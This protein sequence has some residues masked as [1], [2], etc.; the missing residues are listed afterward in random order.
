MKSTHTKDSFGFTLI[1]LLVVIAI[2]AI[3]ASLLLPALAS[4]KNKA[5]RVK[6]ISNEKQLG[7]ALIVYSDTSADFYPAYA[8]YAA[9]GGQKGAVDIAG[10]LSNETSRV[11]NKFVQGVEVFHCPS[12]HG[13]ALSSTLIASCWTSYGNS[14]LM[15][16]HEDRYSVQYCGGDSQPYNPGMPLL[17]PIKSTTIAAKPSTKII[18]SDW[19]WFADRNINSPQSAWHNNKGNPTF[20]T[21]FGDGHVEYY[22]FPPNRTTYDRMTPN[23]TNIWW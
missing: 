14:Y 21:L 2:I 4:A 8:E 5:L 23:Q 12:D 20:P 9:W 11:V 19:P 18:L 22:K 3:L 6:C 16:W 10:G 13:D 7:L 15:T 17:P 1:E